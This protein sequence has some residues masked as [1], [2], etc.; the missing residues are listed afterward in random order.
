MKQPERPDLDR[1]RE[2]AR[3]GEGKQEKAPFTSRQGQFLAFIHLYRKL[4]RR[5]PS[6]VEMARFFRLTPPAVHL[7]VVKLD[8]LGLITRQAGVA[9]SVEVAVSAEQ[10][11]ALE[12]VE[13]P[14]W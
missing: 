3:R 9:R 13:G 5:G 1:A 7:M 14:P 4:H 10:I 2:L 12:D 8:E 11:P 6:E